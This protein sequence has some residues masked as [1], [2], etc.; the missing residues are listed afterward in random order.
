[1]RTSKLQTFLS[2]FLHRKN[3]LQGISNRRRKRKFDPEVFFL[4]I[5][6][7]KEKK[8]NR[9]QST[10]SLPSEKWISLEKHFGERMSFPQPLLL[11]RDP[12][13]TEKLQNGFVNEEV[14]K[15]VAMH[16]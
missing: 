9:Q 1:L 2:R 12:T 16:K 8:R 10:W 11:Q 3:D 13:P 5:R 6:R 15:I 7:V 4:A 14:C